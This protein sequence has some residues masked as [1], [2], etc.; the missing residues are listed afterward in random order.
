MEKF[1]MDKTVQAIENHKN[2][3]QSTSSTIASMGLSKVGQKTGGAL[4]TPAVWVLNYADKGSIPDKLDAG[5]YGMGFLGSIAS[6]AAISV[7][8]V[9]AI[10]DDD[11]DTRLRDV[12]NTE[13]PKYQA[14][15]QP[16]YRY[17]MN[18]PQ[19]NATTIASKGGTAW[20]HANGLWV[21]I[22]DAKGR[23]VHD[24][25]PKKYIQIYR[26]K[27]PLTKSRSGN[28]LWESVK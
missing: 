8:T 11:I 5:L 19:I 16:C 28:F 13:D 2:I 27:M 17:A 25:K 24:F 3:I 4:V 20:Q 6:V 21:Y 23:L 10:V 12:Q 26:P 7:G 18:P 9:K 22:M 1:I 14:F 15:I